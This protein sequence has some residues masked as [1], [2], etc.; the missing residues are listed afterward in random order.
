M[1]E[2]VFEKTDPTVESVD[3]SNA[4]LRQKAEQ[5]NLP[6]ISLSETSNKGK[7]KIKAT[8]GK[9]R[10]GD[11]MV[12]RAE[13]ADTPETDDIYHEEV[14]SRTLIELIVVLPYYTNR[15]ANQA[16]FSSA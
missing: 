9:T 16:V 11:A 6:D 5:E 12:D 1:Y 15:D 8:K 7:G 13:R 10:I 4:R 2:D 3:D 14:R